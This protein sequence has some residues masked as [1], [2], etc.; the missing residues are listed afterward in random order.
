MGHPDLSDAERDAA[1]PWLWIPALLGAAVVFDI[2][3][4]SQDIAI[5]RLA[6]DALEALALTVAAVLAWARWRLVLGPSGVRSA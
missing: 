4:A 3:G 1:W 5:L 6:D 2:V